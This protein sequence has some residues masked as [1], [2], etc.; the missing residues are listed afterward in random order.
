MILIL[1]L[2]MSCCCL[3]LFGSGAGYYLYDKAAAEEE[4]AAEAAAAAAEEAEEAEAAAAAAAAQRT[5]AAA[6]AT[7]RRTAAAA[8][9]LAIKRRAAAA[10]AQKNSARAKAKAA[11]SQKSAALIATRAAAVV[12]RSDHR[13]GNRAKGAKCGAGRCCSVLGYCGTTK[14]YCGEGCQQNAGKC[15]TNFNM[16][17]WE[18]KNYA[19]YTKPYTDFANQPMKGTLRTCMEKCRELNKKGLYCAGFTREKGTGASYS[20]CW[21]KKKFPSKKVNDPKYYSFVLSVPPRG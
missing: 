19:Q 4:A 18:V 5:A 17:F 7:K 21:L 10:V 9:A 15:D 13:C 3:S 20:K 14:D 16:K 11:A 12:E 8:A 6:L 2:M 1:I